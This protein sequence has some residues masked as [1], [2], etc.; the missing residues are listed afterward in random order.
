MQPAAYIA[1]QFSQ[2]AGI[3]PITPSSGIGE[4]VDIGKLRERKSFW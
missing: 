2:V 3:Y 1:Y 4:L